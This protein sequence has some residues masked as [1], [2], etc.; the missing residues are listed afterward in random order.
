MAQINLVANDD[1]VLKIY[2][3]TDSIA[4]KFEAS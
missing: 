3:R 4:V 1:I 2:L